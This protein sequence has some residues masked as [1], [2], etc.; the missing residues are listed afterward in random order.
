MKSL[1]EFQEANCTGCFYS[2]PEKVGTGGACCTYP[3]LPRIVD[4]KCLTRKEATNAVKEEDT[5]SQ[6][7]I[8]T[9]RH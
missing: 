1:K 6:G 5:G 8:D 7:T 9:H 3:G 4:D 2:I